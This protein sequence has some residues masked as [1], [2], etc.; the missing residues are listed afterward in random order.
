MGRPN[1][2]RVD[3]EGKKGLKSSLSRLMKARTVWWGGGEV[4]LLGGPGSE[5]RLLIGRREKKKADGDKWDGKKNKE[6]L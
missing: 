5:L 1:S 3:K 4:S 2:T 6:K